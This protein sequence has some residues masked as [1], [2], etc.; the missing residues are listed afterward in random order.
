MFI[1]KLWRSRAAP[2][3]ALCLAACGGSASLLT[4]LFEFG[5]SGSSAGVAIQVF[6]LPD[7]PTTATG[8]FDGVNMNVGQVQFRYTGSYSGC[9]FSLSAAVAVILIH[10]YRRYS[11]NSEIRFRQTEEMKTSLR[12]IDGLPSKPG[13]MVLWAYR[14]PDHRFGMEH[15]QLLTEIPEIGVLIDEDFPAHGSG[16]FPWKPTV[17]VGSKSAVR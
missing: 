7:T 15:T 12:T 5:F 11:V 4:P 16:Y 10:S 3:V 2:V 17:R 9:D 13:D 6:F 8:T 1:T 14:L